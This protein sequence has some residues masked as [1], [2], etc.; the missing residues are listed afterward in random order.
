MFDKH[1]RSFK[2]S[3]RRRRTEQFLEWAQENPDEVLVVQQ[4]E[5][6]EALKELLRQESAL[7]PRPRSGD[8]SRRARRERHEVSD[9]PF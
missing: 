3:A 9:V 6:D 8:R 4:A 7:A 2:G 1:R 5:A